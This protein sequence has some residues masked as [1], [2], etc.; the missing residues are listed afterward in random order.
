[1]KEMR[2][3]TEEEESLKFSMDTLLEASGYQPL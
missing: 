1:M 2:E 3:L